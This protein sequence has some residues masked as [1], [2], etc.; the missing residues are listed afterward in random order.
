MQTRLAM[1]PHIPAQSRLLFIR[2]SDSHVSESADVFRPDLTFQF[3]VRITDMQRLMVELTPDFELGGFAARVA[4][5]P[6]YGEGSTEDEA[7][8][9]LMQ[10]LTAYIEAFG[11]DDAVGRLNSPSSLR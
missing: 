9:D 6:A 7:M 1:Q 8:A 2:Q 5:I 4:D 3:G 10:A 11:L